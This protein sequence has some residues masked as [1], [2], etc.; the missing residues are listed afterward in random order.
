MISLIDG[1][2]YA[3]ANGTFTRHLRSHGLTYQ[4]YHETHVTGVCPLC[5][6][7]GGQVPLRQRNNT[8]ARTCGSKQCAGAMIAQT[9][10][11]KTSDEKQTIASKR[12]RTARSRSEQQISES[13]SKRKS[14]TRDRWG[15]DHPMQLA[16]VKAKVAA[17]ILT[18]TGVPH[19]TQL[20]EFQKNRQQ[21]YQ[22]K[23]GVGHHMQME[24][25]AAK[26]SRSLKERHY[27]DRIGHLDQLESIYHT[28]GIA[29]VENSLGVTTSTAYR[30]LRE[31]SIALIKTEFSRLELSIQ[32]WVRDH[33]SGTMI[34]GDRSLIGPLEVDIY[35]PDLNLAI[36]CNGA[37]WHSESRGRGPEYHLNKTQLLADQGIRLIH[38]FDLDWYGQTTAAQ[39]TLTAAILRPCYSNLVIRPVDMCAAAEFY[40]HHTLSKWVATHNSWAAYDADQIVG[41]V[42]ILGNAVTAHAG[43]ITALIPAL[44][45]GIT[46]ACD[47][48]HDGV[49]QFETGGMVRVGDRPPERKYTE[50]NVWDCGH[51]IYQRVH[52]ESH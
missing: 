36:E 14:T 20:P 8:Y 31:N 3:R 44:P 4:E 6:A 29:A 24:S 2:D 21:A 9:Y 34:C 23:H 10:Q 33:Y 16:Q 11:S 37:H 26:V 1:V 13:T 43:H 39:N 7:C 27:S 40:S 25:V 48:A 5:E 49:R 30:L 52:D 22:D 28:G 17:T 50:L 32:G 18:A 12:S 51:R 46:I 45:T 38:M 47:L 19:H 41:V 15:V 35:V 42:S